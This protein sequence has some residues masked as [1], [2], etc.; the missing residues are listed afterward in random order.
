MST[1]LLL[2]Q[3]NGKLGSAIHV[4]SIPALDTCPGSSAICRSACYALR[5]RFRFQQVRDRL[6]WNRQ[7][8]CRDDFVDRMVAEIRTQGVL[9]VRLHVAGDFP[10]VE[11]ARKWLAIIQ[12]LPR[13]RFYGYT[14]SWRL[15]RIAAV[16]EQIAVLS[17]MRLWYSVDDETG[18]PACIPSAVRLAYLQTTK[19]PIPPLADLVFRVPPLRTLAT[20]PIVCE[21]ETMEGKQARVTCGSCTRCFR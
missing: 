5:H 21:S 18:V 8:S 16:L 2:Q 10:D 1:P 14:R 3:G 4:W 6:I 11:Y 17:S 19:H 20:L 9:V 13:V 15:P 7:Q 12:Q